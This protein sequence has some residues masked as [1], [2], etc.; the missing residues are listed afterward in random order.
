ME[1]TNNAMSSMGDNYEYNPDNDEIY[2][3]V[4]TGPA[5]NPTPLT[6]YKDK[7]GR[8]YYWNNG[9]K[10]Y[11][12]T[13]PYKS[14]SGNKTTT[15]NK[16]TTTGSSV[17]SANAAREAY[18]Q[19]QQ[20]LMEQQQQM[21]EQQRQRQEELAAQRQQIAQ[22]AYDRN[23]AAYEN[24]FAERRATLDSNLDSTMRNLQ[25]D[26]DA[27]KN[28]INTDSENSLRE[29]YINYM[30]NQKNLSQA[31]SAQGI[32]GGAAETTIAGIGNTYGNARN[33]I[34]V[35]T[36]DNLTDLER[37]YNQNRN[38][39]NQ[40]YNDQLAADSLAKANYMTQ[41]ESDLANSIAQAYTDRINALDDI[42]ANYYNIMS[43]LAAAQQAYAPVAVSAN[44]TPKVV[45]VY[46]G[47][48][49]EETT[50]KNIDAG[51]TEEVGG[52]EAYDAKT[53]TLANYAKMLRN[54]GATDDYILRRLNSSGVTDEQVAYILNELGISV[55]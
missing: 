8:I 6:Y 50:Q 4:S 49:G 40:N 39:A 9:K 17:S 21:L 42:D 33:A 36:L 47:A 14:T 18:L 5:T 22:D 48:T 55:I 12:A 25:S 37:L 34:D 41:L 32:T 43:Q 31:L 26:Y 51:V 30:N 24:A 45:D 13:N 20:A 16:T 23:K 2:K 27:S 44:N 3:V 11:A 19:Q 46:Q 7:Q 10:M 54:G 1:K 35:T 28:S 29:A 15:A 52:E 38:T 53:V